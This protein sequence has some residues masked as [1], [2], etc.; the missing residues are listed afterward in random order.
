MFER[1]LHEIFYKNIV[2]YCALII[3]KMREHSSV[4]LSSALSVWRNK[5]L[6]I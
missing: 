2:Q 6:I 3:F 5:G 1:F 4:L